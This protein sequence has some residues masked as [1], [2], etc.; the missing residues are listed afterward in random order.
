MTRQG[1]T[2]E[3]KVGG[4]E[5]LLE[6]K[7]RPQGSKQVTRQPVCRRE[8]A[9]PTATARGSTEH[10]QPHN[11][12]GTPGAPGWR[13]RLSALAGSGRAAPESRVL[14]SPDKGIRAKCADRP[15]RQGLEGMPSQSPHGTRSQQGFHS[16][17]RKRDS[18]Q[19]EQLCRDPGCGTCSGHKEFDFKAESTSQGGNGLR[20]SQGFVPGE[21]R[22]WP[23]GVGLCINCFFHLI[24]YFIL[25]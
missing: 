6:A 13:C 3:G 11:S 15:P 9:L 17:N 21:S 14:T 8:G 23:Q 4:R 5:R 10:G 12:A 24:G 25:F 20:D 7:G 19:R 16:G 22:W 1:R 18:P 2:P